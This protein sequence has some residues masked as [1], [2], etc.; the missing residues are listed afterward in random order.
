ML[1][2]QAV[3]AAEKFMDT[4]LDASL[5]DKI[6]AEIESSKE[7]IVLSGMP[8]SGKSTVGKILAESLNRKFIDTDAEIGKKAGIPA[9][10]LIETA[11]DLR[12]DLIR[13]KHRIAVTSGSST[14]T[15]L[16]D[17]VIATLEHYAETG[18]FVIQKQTA[19]IL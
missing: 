10:L 19:P 16:T 12:E 1:V 7:N 5:T 14:P 6:F 8:G 11:D 3:V 18:T 17:A 15:P 13:G 4:T 9:A 2:A